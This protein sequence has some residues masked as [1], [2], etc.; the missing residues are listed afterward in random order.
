[1]RRK[2][3]PGTNRPHIR[4]DANSR[5]EI[6]NEAAR[7]IAEQGIEDYGMAKR[8]AAQ[9]LSFGETRN[10]PTNQ[11]VEDALRAH[12][13]LFYPQQALAL[14]RLRE[15]AL[16][17]MDL[18]HIFEPRLVGAVL[19]GTVTRYSEIQLHITA[20][21]P[22]EV[23]FHLSGY[24]IA[25]EQGEKRVRFG[26]RFTM[27]PIFRFDVEK[28]S[29]ELTVFDSNSIRELPLSPIDGQPMR[30]ANRQEVA[31]ILEHK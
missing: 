14:R 24:G 1:M 26:D 9:R 30:R 10:L 4:N 15:L 20:A 2:S 23:Y 7:I 17:A 8:K 19:N 28:A 21:T 18:V 11:E 5:Q 25:S 22:E 12:L 29:V 27:A 16:E 13:A 3:A 31:T 6:A